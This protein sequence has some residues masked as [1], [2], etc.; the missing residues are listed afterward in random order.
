MTVPD[1]ST[2]PQC[3]TTLPAPVKSGAGH[4]SACPT[5]GASLEQLA[6]PAASSTE[7][8]LGRLTQGLL[9]GLSLPERI[10]R[11]AVGL[12]AG[13]ARELAELLVPHS[14]QDSTS[15]KIAIGNALGFLTETVGG[16]PGKP[17]PGDETAQAAGDQIARKAVGNFVDLAGM[18]TLHVSPMWLLAVVSDVAYGTK[19]YTLEL[20]RELQA[21]GVID[22]TSTIHNVEDILAAVQRTCGSA[23]GKFD[24][25]PLSIDEL[26]KT[27]DETRAS[28]S[29]ADVRKLIPE[30][31]VG[32]LWQDMK[33]IAA[34]EDVSLL[35]V[36]G[37]IAMQTLGRV[38]TVGEGTLIGLRVAGG[39]LNR[40]V[41]DHYVA[42]LSHIHEKG[43]YASLQES[44]GPYV[45]AVWNNFGRDRKSWTEAV[46]D[47]GNVGWLFN[48]VLGLVPGRNAE[49]EN[50]STGDDASPSS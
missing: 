32:R 19:S 23:A 48:K 26:R 15:Y 10:A 16:V 25:P 33:G 49:Q 27:I 14:F 24:Q 12:T 1:T 35:N 3:Q 40:T 20:A 8:P 13:T 46:L 9:Y 47:P 34:A 38:K 6:S 7:T 39:I 30:S 2:C 43:Y 45:T 44:C 37:A 31:E 22:E 4:P 36:S 17:V 41:L 42:S 5:C 18:A 11:G 28:L 50:A 21:R 29:Q